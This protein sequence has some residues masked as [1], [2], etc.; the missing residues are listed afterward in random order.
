MRKYL[1]PLLVLG[2]FASVSCSD[3]ESS[4]V[5]TAIED[6]TAFLFVA[7]ER[8]V[9]AEN[10]PEVQGV[11]ATVTTIQP[12]PVTLNLEIIDETAKQGVDFEILS[13]A[14]QIVIPA[15]EASGVMLFK[16]IDNTLADGSRTFKVKISSISPDNIKI[17]TKESFHSEATIVISNDDCGG[18]ETG[19]YGSS[20]TEVYTGDGSGG[21]N[22]GP[23]EWPSYV[24]NIEKAGCVGD[25]VTYNVDDV[26]FGHYSLLYGT[27]KN[28]GVF[29]L[30]LTTN[31][32]EII[33]ASSPD[34]IY[35][36]DSFFGSG[37]LDPAAGMAQIS[38]S[39]NWGDK[40]VVTINLN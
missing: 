11:V 32:I 16:P 7:G 25:L 26:T 6:N 18:P 3:D 39:N 15:N 40:G 21:N 9:Y 4:I 13:D 5:S 30:D 27:G 1:L 8:T 19:P 20:S 31:E 12:F 14:R 23:F 29:T 33:E 24:I 34:V 22:Q 36:G 17:S 35:G 37:N 10:A 28:P 38:W 2:I